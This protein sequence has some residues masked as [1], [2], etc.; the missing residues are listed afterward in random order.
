MSNYYIYF[1]TAVWW[2]Q[3]RLFRQVL[4]AAWCCLARLVSAGTHPSLEQRLGGGYS[5]TPSNHPS[6]FPG[7][8]ASI[9][10][11]GQTVSSDRVMVTF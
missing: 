6:F 3:L 7:R 10:A 8:Q 1:D 4:T 11:R 2:V 5:W 9:T